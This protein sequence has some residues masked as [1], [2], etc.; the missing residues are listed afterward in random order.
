[1]RN[2]VSRFTFHVLEEET[3]DNTKITTLVYLV[4]HGVTEWNVQRRFQGQMEVPLSGEGFVQAAAVASWLAGQPVRFSAIYTSDLL[5][6]MQTAQE[7]G[8]RLRIQP[9]PVAALREIHCGEWQGLS[10]EAV[11]EHYPGSLDEWRNHVD[12][13]TLPGGESIPEVQQRTFDFYRRAVKQHEGEAIIFVSH[14]AALSALQTSAYG[15]DLRETWGLGKTRLGNTGVTVLSVDSL[16]G[17]A[18][19]LVHNS[20]VHLEHPTGISSVLDRSV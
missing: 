6:A 7:I 9:E 3:L 16:S 8:A 19:L 5:R 13:F 11:E 10:V 2:H 17:R 14:G 4:R 18:N 12:S 1:M 15:W 20:I